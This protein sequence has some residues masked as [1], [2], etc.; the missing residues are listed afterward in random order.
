M[1]RTAQLL[2]VSLLSAAPALAQAP[3]PATPAAVVPAAATKTPK[4]DV[5]VYDEKADAQ[6]DVAAA[7][8]RAKKD[9][10]RVLIQWGGNWCPWCLLLAATMQNDQALRT[11]LFNEYEVVHVDIGKFDKNVEL[12]KQ[13]GAELRVVAKAVPFLTILD[14]SGK[15]IW[16]Q[17]TELFEIK[18]ENGKG[19]HDPK[20]LV[21]FLT[22]HQVALPTAKA[23]HAAALASAKSEHKRVFLHFGAP[24]CGWCIRLESWMARP[25]IAAL[26]AK[27]FVDV[28]IDN[29]RMEGGADMYKAELAASGVKDTGIPWFVFSDADGKQIAAS[30]GPKTTIGFP[31]EVDEVEAF[32]AMLQKARVN[33]TDADIKTLVDSLHAGRIADEAKRKA[34]AETRAADEPKRKAEAG[35]KTSGQ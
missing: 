28:K 21:E 19:G 27:D 17:N 16:Q 29:D 12:S 9:N 32:A 33:L 34:E 26:L 4:A 31:Y 13:L 23:A 8:A 3:V 30:N 20:K 25:E 24:W 15:P 1:Q 14:N 11:K 10:K 35:K 5:A 2:F 6:K 7:V 22:E 18:D